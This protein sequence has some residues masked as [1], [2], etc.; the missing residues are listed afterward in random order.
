[1]AFLTLEDLYGKIEVIAFPKVLEKSL[2]YTGEDSVLSISGRLSLRSNA[3]NPDE[4]AEV[5][6]IAEEIHFG[7]DLHS[8]DPRPADLRSAD[9]NAHLYIKVPSEDCGELRLAEKYIAY[10]DGSTPLTIV[11]ADTG[12]RISGPPVDLHEPLLRE[13]CAVL[14]GDNVKTKPVSV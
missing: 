11:F 5:S 3:E 13:L 6:L 2:A 12:R 1:M 10:F 14:G 9:G 7:P 8:A 4:K